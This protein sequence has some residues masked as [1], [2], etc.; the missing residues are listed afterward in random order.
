V[1]GFSRTTARIFPST[2]STL[3]FSRRPCGP[4]VQTVADLMKT[5][6]GTS[7]G[8]RSFCAGA[9]VSC[10]RFMKGTLWPCQ[11]STSSKNGMTRKAATSLS[12]LC[13]ALSTRLAGS[14][15]AV[16]RLPGAPPPISTAATAG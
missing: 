3:A 6:F 4:L 15:T 13:S 5:A 11:I 9:A 7:N 10:A 16:S 8:L 1:S 2:M 12:A 14:S